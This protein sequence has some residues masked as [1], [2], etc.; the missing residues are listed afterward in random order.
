MGSQPTAYPDQKIMRQSFELAYHLLSCEAF[1]I[2]F[3][4]PQAL[5]VF[6]DF[7]FHAAAALVVEVHIRQQDANGVSEAVRGLAG[8][9]PD[10]LWRQSRHEHA[11]APLTILLAAAHRNALD[12]AAVDIGRL[13]HPTHL[14]VGITRVGEP[15][16]NRFGQLFGA[17]PRVILAMNLVVAFQGPIDIL[18]ATPTRLNP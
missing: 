6:F 3:G 10:I 18:R 1:L 7:D 15:L 16:C 8:Q 13:R 12:R 17:P 2:A 5:L 4:G 9:E 14:T 11:D